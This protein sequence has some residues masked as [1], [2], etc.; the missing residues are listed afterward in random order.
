MPSETGNRG[1]IT[2]SLLHYEA[3]VNMCGYNKLSTK[4]GCALTKN[5]KIK[6]VE[7]V[8]NQEH[9]ILMDPDIYH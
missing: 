3:D 7:L 5:G 8:L 6:I 9:K 4:P 1:D 2:C